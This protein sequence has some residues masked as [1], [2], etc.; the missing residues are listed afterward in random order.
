MTF[1]IVMLLV[2]GGFAAFGLYMQKGPPRNRT[3][4]QQIARYRQGTFVLTGWA[5]IVLIRILT[6]TY[7]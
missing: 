2:S 7:K 5:I 4:P 3:S 1:E 6:H